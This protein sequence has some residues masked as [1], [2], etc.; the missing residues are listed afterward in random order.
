MNA[1]YWIEKFNL[2]KHPEGGYYKEIYR[3]VEQ[4][5]CKALPGRYQTNR[6]F[7]TSIYFLL[8]LGQ[9]SKFHKLQSDEIWYFHLGNPVKAYFMDAN[10]KCYTKL[11]GLNIENDERP[12]MIFK[13]Q[14][15]FAAEILKGNHDYSLISCAVAPG[16]EFNDFELANKENMLKQF[17]GYAEIVLKF[18]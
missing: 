1:N 17:P 15:W 7:L 4:I 9:V 16:F 11:L 13:K 5:D 8:K 2:I 12:Q 6:S 3:S 10:G 14:T 18:T